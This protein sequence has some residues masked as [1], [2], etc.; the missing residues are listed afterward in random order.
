MMT[1]QCTVKTGHTGAGNH[2]EKVIY[3]IARDIIEA[4]NIARK[5][6]GVKKGRSNSSGQSILDI[7]RIN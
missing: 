2:G 5:K 6:G 4:M 3:I 7:K 1:Y